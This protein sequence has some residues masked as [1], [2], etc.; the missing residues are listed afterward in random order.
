MK[1]AFVNSLDAPAE[2][3]AILYPNEVGGH[4]LDQDEDSSEKRCLKYWFHA[5]DGLNEFGHFSPG[6]NP[7]GDHLGRGYADGAR[8]HHHGVRC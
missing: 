3:G 5:V 6:A 4:G 8:I 2:G 1:D 7:V